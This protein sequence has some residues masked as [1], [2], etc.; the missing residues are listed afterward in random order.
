M[1]T[2][3]IYYGRQEEADET[4]KLLLAEKVYFSIALRT[5]FS[6]DLL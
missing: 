6:D 4:V 2:A 3:F 5:S 1:G